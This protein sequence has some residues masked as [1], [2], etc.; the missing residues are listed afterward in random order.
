MR[1]QRLK[2]LGR[3]G[4]A[5]LAGLATLALLSALALPFETVTVP[6]WRI[7]YVDAAGQPFSGLRVRQI[8][9][10]HQ[11]KAEALRAYAVSNAKGVV[12]FP[13]RSLN[14]SALARAGVQLELALGLRNGQKMLAPSWVNHFC[15][16]SEATF[17][18]YNADYFPTKVQLRHDGSAPGAQAGTRMPEC[19]GLERQATLARHKVAGPDGAPD[20][21]PDEGPDEVPS[22]VPDRVAGA[23]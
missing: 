9:W 2:I 18:D 19:D 8:W 14:A 3:R 20:G 13:E 22:R 1:G 4:P 15:H 6:E 21:A 16:F 11:L 23:E 5:L 17:S 10:P 12:V 7:R